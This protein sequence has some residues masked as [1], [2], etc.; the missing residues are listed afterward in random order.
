MVLVFIAGVGA[1]AVYVAVRPTVARG[2]V[3]GAKL[4]QANSDKLRAMDCNDAPIG[5]EGAHFSC[6]ATFKDGS[7]Q[8]VEFAMD[9][10][11]GLEPASA[12]P[13]VKRT[14]DPWGD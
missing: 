3:L 5:V 14:T 12:H 9:R 7:Q 8:V 1:A 11:G 2:T 13:D 10:N 4:L 6:Q